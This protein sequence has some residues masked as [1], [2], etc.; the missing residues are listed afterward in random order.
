MLQKIVEPWIQTF[1]G[2]KFWLDSPQSESIH[3]EDI[4]HSLSMQCR[5]AGHSKFF[6]SVAQH[7]YLATFL[8]PYSLRLAV[9]LHDAAE[10]YLGDV[11]KPLKQCLGGKYSH[12]E[13][14]VQNA[15]DFKYGLRLSSQDILGIKLLL[16]IL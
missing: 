5:Y 16:H 11:T 4:A 1:T 7:S 10:A 6:Y 3:I 15:I 9:L 12:M 8:C 13:A 2:Q 14:K